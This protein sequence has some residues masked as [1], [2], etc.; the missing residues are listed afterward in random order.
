MGK[1]EKKIIVPTGYMGSGSSA[2]TD[3]F[4]EIQNVD[5]SR[6]TFEFVFLHCPNGV[7]D[8]ED[9]LLIG[10]NALRSDEAL[11]NFYSTMKQL[12]DKKYWWVGHY[13]QNVG[14]EFLKETEKYIENITEFK[15]DFFWYYQ[16]NVNF[17]MVPKLAVNKIL[18][19]L[20]AGKYKGE[21]PL[22]YSPIWLSYVTPEVFYSRSREYIYKVLEMAGYDKESIVLDQ[23]LLPFNLQRIDNYFEDD[24]EVFVVERDPRDMFIINKYFWSKTNDVLPYQTDAKKFCEY[25]KKMRSIEKDVDKKNVHRIKFEDLIYRYDETIEKI[26][27]DLNWSA[28][29]HVRKKQFFDPQKSI[30]NTQ[31]F[32]RNPEY[33]EESK[34][35]E[36]ELKEFLYDFPYEITSESEN[37]F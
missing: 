7:F 8:L 27:T 29:R 30:N 13:K 4:H 23:L 1:D 9:K 26:F 6:G 37:V 25:Y 2:I 33:Y 17:K 20:T 3:I 11:H 16:E 32:N 10:N 21:K 36:N 22:R 18:K 24:L 5:V 35:I 19:I 28:D 34:I 12:Y 31:L 15:S 14:T